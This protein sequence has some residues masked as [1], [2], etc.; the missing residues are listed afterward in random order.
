[1]A[2]QVKITMDKFQQLYL[3]NILGSPFSFSVARNPVPSRVNKAVY[4]GALGN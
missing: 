2:V 3:C 1:M 4:K